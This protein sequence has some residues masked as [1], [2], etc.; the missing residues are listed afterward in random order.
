MKKQNIKNK[1]A[2]N[3]AIVTELNNSQMTNVQGGS[4]GAI[5]DVVNDIIDDIKDAIDNITKPIITR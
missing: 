1:L 5:C 3:R 2:F 4:T